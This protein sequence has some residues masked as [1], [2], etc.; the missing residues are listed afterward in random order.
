M[1]ITSAQRQAVEALDLPF[2]LS[3]RDIH[4]QFNP[5]GTTIPRDQRPT[6]VRV[7]ELARAAMNDAVIA[8]ND[9]RKAA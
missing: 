5:D 2:D 3:E 4:K 9:N 7:R 1:N 6:M 8:A